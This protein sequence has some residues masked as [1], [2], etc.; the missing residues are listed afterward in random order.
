MIKY[1]LQCRCG[2]G[3]EGWFR[4]SD[5][6]EAQAAEGALACPRCGSTEVTKAIMAPRIGKAGP[7]VGTAG[8]SIGTAGSSIGTAGS[9]IGTAGSSIG[10]AGSS[11]G[12]E[13]EAVQAV[14]PRSGAAPDGPQ[15]KLRA[16]LLE[17]RRAV[18]TSCDDV[19]PAFAEEA[20]KIHYGEAEARGI[21]GRA[22]A[23]EA[24]ALRDEGIEVA[25]IPW[26]SRGDA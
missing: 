23:E 25:A 11:I 8:S 5:T 13:G 19:G 9:S 15:A 18:E 2:H 21:Y 24:E 3:F 10:T 12:K 14:A 22:S 7:R 26:V 17:L 4:N 6:F 20:R 1:A 16:K